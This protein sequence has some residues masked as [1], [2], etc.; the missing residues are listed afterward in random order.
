MET[1]FVTLYPLV[2][3]ISFSGYV[4]QIIKLARAKSPVDGISLQSWCT[5]IANCII[6]MGYGFFPLQDL[7]FVATMGTSMTSMLIVVSLVLYNRH[8][9]FA[10]VQGP[11][12]PMVSVCELRAAGLV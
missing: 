10:K 5:W 1:V 4:P 2:A 6:S 8:W 11:I 3:F 7:M 12:R 9:R